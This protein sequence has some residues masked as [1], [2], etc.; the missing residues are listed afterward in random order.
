[1]KDVQEL[2]ALYETPGMRVTTCAFVVCHALCWL[3][4][5]LVEFC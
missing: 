1:M 4:Q 5:C 3:K 2:I